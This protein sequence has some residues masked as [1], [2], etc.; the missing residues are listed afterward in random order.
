MPTVNLNK[1]EF[2]KLVG[3]KLPLEELKDRISMLGTDLEKIEGN[4]IIVE[5]FPNRPDMLSEQGFA[6]AFSSFIGV[7][8]GLQEYKAKKSN[9]KVIIEKNVKEV[10][11]FTT[12]AVVKNL[13]L[14]DEKIKSIIQ[15]QE[16][17]HIGFGRNRRKVAIGIYPL[18]KIK[19]PV[20]FLAKKPEDIKFKPL[21]MSA[22]LSGREILEKHPAGREYRHLLENKKMYPVFI[23][24]N[25]N[26]LSMPPII[27]SDEIGKVTEDT[28][29]VF[30]E[31]S[32]FDYNA[33]SKCMNIIVTALAD[34]EGDIYS[35]EL[36]YENEKIISPD[37]KPEEM[38]LD[39]DYANKV[40][41]L[42]LKE[43]EAKELLERMGYGYN[44]GEV[45][46]PAY[47]ADILHQIDLVEDI[48]IAYGYENF[49]EEIPNVS[50]VAKESPRA[51][52]NRK[53]SE[54]L[55]G[56]GLLECSGLS[57][58]NEE[59]LNK[60]MNVKNKLVKVE[61]PVNAD[62]D[63]LRNSILPSLLNILSENKRYEYPQDI[64]EIGKIFDDIKDKDNLGMIIT[65]NFTEI[66][67]ILDALFSALAIK[68]EIKE[69]EHGSFISGRCGKIII[70]DKEIG[71]IGEIHP[72]VLINFRLEMCCSGLEIDI[73]ELFE[74]IKND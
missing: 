27:N 10:R 37:L 32:G 74:I 58:S 7:K 42:K 41:G 53:V 19:F 57:L 13:K 47:R 62:Y 40:L 36:K 18:E 25:D 30:I 31:C 49:K 71:V 11:P 56:L 14:D 55:I 22:I 28:R 5:V 4:D 70:N 26:V 63:T 61:S 67:Q 17:L 65:G 6:R 38:N 46:I 60:K 24:A 48:A 69:E 68:Y 9:Y 59:D 8:K 39:L 12:C 66:K 15:I 3:K 51:K 35:V 33:L 16:K 52:F 21:E 20:K 23:D 50:T 2:E 72:R 29:D 64:F 43:N 54:V 1:K 45:K 73:N 44:K 34:M